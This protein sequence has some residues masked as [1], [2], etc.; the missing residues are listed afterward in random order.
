VAQKTGEF[1]M[2]PAHSSRMVS[3]FKPG[4][5]KGIFFD[6]KTHFHYSKKTV[7]MINDFFAE[8]TAA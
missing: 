5:T 4:A 1:S 3:R 6:R 2:L 7:F 8:R